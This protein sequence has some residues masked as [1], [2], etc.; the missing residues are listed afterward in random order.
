MNT[1]D[2]QE[3]TLRVNLA[4]EAL[5]EHE[6]V[7]DRPPVVANLARALR[8]LVELL[9]SSPEAAT[10][11]MDPRQEYTEA[12]HQ[13]GTDL[14]DA[15]GHVRARFKRGEISAVEAADERIDLM[16]RNQQLIRKIRRDH[17]DAPDAGPS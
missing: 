11:I 2:P 9:D 7:G 14:D 10:L 16:T 1:T 8:L 4:R 3:L 15:L 12:L 6:L 17:G 13:A 5:A